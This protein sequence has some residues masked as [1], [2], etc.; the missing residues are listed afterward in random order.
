MHTVVLNANEITKYI[1][2]IL[3]GN[4]IIFTSREINKIHD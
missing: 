2:R 4:K 1:Q 3:N